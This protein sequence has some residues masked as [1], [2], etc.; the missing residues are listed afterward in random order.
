M[1]AE[2][3]FYLKRLETSDDEYLGLDADWKVILLKW[4]LRKIWF[5]DVNLTDQTQ[6]KAWWLRIKVT[7]TKFQASK[8]GISASHAVLREPQVNR[9]VTVSY[10]QTIFHRRDHYVFVSM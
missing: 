7:L 10:A 2:Q 6:D 1:A 4:I 3:E 9:A 8:Q 5:E